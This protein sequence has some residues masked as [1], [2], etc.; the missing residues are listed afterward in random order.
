[1][2]VTVLDYDDRLQLRNETDKPLI[3]LGYEGEPYLAFRDGKV[4]RNTHSPATYL[5]DD[6]FGRVALPKQADPKAV[7]SWDEVSSP[8]RIRLV[9]TTASTG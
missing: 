7:S 1:M 3:I 4:Y 2:T 6:R 5:N 8:A 9:M